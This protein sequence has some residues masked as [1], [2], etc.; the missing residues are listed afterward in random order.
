MGRILPWHS[1]C[2]WECVGQC[3]SPLQQWCEQFRAVCDRLV[4]CNDH[5]DAV[6]VCIRCSSSIRTVYSKHWWQSPSQQSHRYYLNKIAIMIA[7]YWA[8]AVCCTL[9]GVGLFADTAIAQGTCI[10]V[11]TGRG[12]P[13]IACFNAHLF[14]AV[15]PFAQLPRH[16]LKKYSFPL[17]SELELDASGI[18]NELRCINDANDAR[19]KPN[20]AFY[21]T[22][23]HTNQWA[24]MLI[25]FF[26]LW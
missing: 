8:V 7:C 20:T 10:G 23:C 4:D 26:F 17:S 19:T 16:L 22:Y 12:I 18:G 5:C 25:F 1:T 3:E 6:D 24:S 13:V 14:V 9:D 21:G 11:Y 2:V 15:I